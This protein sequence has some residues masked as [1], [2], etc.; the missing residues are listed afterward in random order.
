MY[1][2]MLIATDGS[3]GARTAAERGLELAREL[4]AS[5]VAFSAIESGPHAST[6][7][8]ELRTDERAEAEAAADDLARRAE[9]AGLEATS[10]TREGV[11]QEAVV[12]HAREADVDLIVTGTGGR[13]GLDHLLSGSV[14]E[15]VIREAPAPVLTVR[16][17]E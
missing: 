17:G 8:D 15:E 2:R 10:A 7:R 11:P 4:D 1:D 14:A 16:V 3:D 5:V 12:A 13:T 6:T 9:R